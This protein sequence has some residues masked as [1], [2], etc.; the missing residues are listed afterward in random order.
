[1]F[2][3]VAKTTK[4]DAFS[5]ML[6]GFP[7]EDWDISLCPYGPKWD[8][9]MPLPTEISLMFP[10][11]GILSRRPGALGLAYAGIGEVR[12]TWLLFS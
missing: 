12:R 1:M 11:H 3:S 8:K 9:C 10:Q 5:G 2:S 6:N 4:I 7:I